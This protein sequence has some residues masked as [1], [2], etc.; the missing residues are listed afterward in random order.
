MCS[1]NRCTKQGSDRASDAQNARCR[2]SLGGFTLIELI[3]IVAIL[4]ILAA[5]VLP[6]F[7]GHIQQAKESQAKANLKILRDAVERYAYDHNGVPPGYPMN[8]QNL[9]PNYPTF[10]SQVIVM[11]KYLKKLPA[12]PFNDSS[13]VQVLP[14]NMPYNPLGAYPASVGWIYHPATKTVKLNQTG[15]DSQGVKY[16][17]Y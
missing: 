17:D 4:G 2:C 7:Q 14:N 12:N 10:M 5:I 9:N 8:N 3:I 13:V 16:S 11:G 6:E 1:T 15:T